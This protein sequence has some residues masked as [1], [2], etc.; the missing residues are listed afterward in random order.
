MSGMSRTLITV[1]VAVGLSVG[2]AI[3]GQAL[4]FSEFAYLSALLVVG[5]LVSLTDPHRF[6]W[7]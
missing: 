6:G 7:R 5:M 1:L 2:V 3:A 4:G